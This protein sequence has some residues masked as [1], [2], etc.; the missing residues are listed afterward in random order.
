[1]IL[2][3]IALC[4]F[5][6]VM[7]V[8]ALEGYRRLTSPNPLPLRLCAAWPLLGMGAPGA[9][10]GPEPA[11]AAAMRGMATLCHGGAR[12]GRRPRCARRGRLRGG[13]VLWRRGPV[14]GR[15]ARRRRRQI[16]ER[17][18]AMGRRAADP[19]AAAPDRCN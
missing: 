12:F 17:R 15:L 10:A 7:A 3:S 4:L 5:T 6:S 18:D 1:M 19:R 2:Q 11:A 9:G 13:G 14:R 16:A 8:A